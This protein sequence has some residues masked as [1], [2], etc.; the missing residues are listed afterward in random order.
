MA[1][2]N[3]A[4]FETT[5]DSS[6]E[7][8]PYD[9]NKNPNSETGSASR[10]ASSSRSKQEYRGH[11][12]YLSDQGYNDGSIRNILEGAKRRRKTIEESGGEQ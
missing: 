4:E 1:K 11:E 7:T 5:G 10:E 8:A 6:E 9:H 3:L 12:L 2:L